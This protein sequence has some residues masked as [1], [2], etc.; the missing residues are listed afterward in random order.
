MFS[1]LVSRTAFLLFAFVASISFGQVDLVRDHAPE[2][3]EPK[4][5]ANVIE[6]LRWKNAQSSAFRSA[7]DEKLDKMRHKQDQI[8]AEL[9]KLQDERPSR[10]RYTSDEMKARLTGRCIEELLTVKLEL[11]T[12]RTMY[13][14]VQQD[15]EQRNPSKLKKQIQALRMKEDLLN[16]QR[17]NIAAQVDRI[18]ELFKQG[19]VSSSQVMQAK[20]EQRQLDAQLADLQVEMATMEEQTTAPARERI[21][22]LRI[23]FE[24][25]NA[26]KSAAEEFLAELTDAFRLE[27]SV[28]RKIEALTKEHELLEQSR[29][30][31]LTKI[32]E[33]EIQS[34]ETQSFLELLEARVSES[35]KQEAD[36][37]S[38]P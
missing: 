37:N 8:Q 23:Q 14:Q 29:L 20:N 17:E 27:R 5:V 34:A 12:T 38:I 11:A 32:N 30:Q 36:S 1:K 28:N 22:D 4:A 10:L 2:Q 19:A 18:S 15:A 21:S 24:A 3:L 7:L 25:M 6:Q 16:K 13:R 35:K 9:V 33:I 26:R 31:I